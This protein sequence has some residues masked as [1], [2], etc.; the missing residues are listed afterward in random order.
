[1]FTK[2][3]RNLL[4]FL[5]IVKLLGLFY[6]K[7]WIFYGVNFF[8]CIQILSVSRDVEKFRVIYRVCKGAVLLP[9]RIRHIRFHV[10]AAS[11]SQS[12][13]PKSPNVA[14]YKQFQCESLTL[15]HGLKTWIENA[16]CSRYFAFCNS[17]FAPIISKPE[18]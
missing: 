12:M 8:S 3:L 15:K 17:A 7:S 4:F 11:D 5:Q 18:S 16:V 6:K 9:H 14:I 1:M 13:A 10:S 2:T